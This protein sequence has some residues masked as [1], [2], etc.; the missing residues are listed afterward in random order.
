MNSYEFTKAKIDDWVQKIGADIRPP[1]EIGL[2]EERFQTFSKWARK[3]HPQVFD[4]MVVGE[5]RFEML[6]TL[7]YPGKPT[8]NVV[9]YTMTQR[10]PVIT[11]PRRVSA[12]DLEPDLPDINDVF[13]SCMKQF[14]RAFPGRRVIRVGK[15]NEYVFDCG[16]IESLPLVAARFSRLDVPEHGEI[17]IRVN[18]PDENHNRIL[19]I[20]H[21]VAVKVPRPGQPLERTGFGVKVVVDVNNRDVSRELGQPDWLTVLDSADIYNRDDVFDVLNC[22]GTEGV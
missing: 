5:Q 16:D 8:A 12:I 22:K 11:V 19:T 6:K 13:V 17:S 7:E 21:L 10:G 3:T 9:T 4:R 1:I 14:L 15:I 20:Q 18:L 2:E